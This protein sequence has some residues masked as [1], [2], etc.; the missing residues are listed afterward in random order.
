MCKPVTATCKSSAPWCG[1]Q[2]SLLVYAPAPCSQ[3]HFVFKVLDEIAA[4]VDGSKLVVS[5]A[6]GVSTKQIE[7]VRPLVCKT[8]V[9]H[10]Q[11]SYRR[12]LARTASGGDM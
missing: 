2:Q 4:V 9:T 10:A 6:A 1:D 11:L 3:P 5:V 8:G 12:V 7:E